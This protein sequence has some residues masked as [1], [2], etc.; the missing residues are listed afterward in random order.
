MTRSG[1]VFKEQAVSQKKN[2][3]WLN[4]PPIVPRKDRLD[5]LFGGDSMTP[6]VNTTM[7]SSCSK[8]KDLL[9]DVPTE[10]AL[11]LSPR[12]YAR[13]ERGKILIERRNKFKLLQKLIS[14][15]NASENIDQFNIMT[16]FFVHADFAEEQRQQDLYHKLPGLFIVENIIRDMQL[17]DSQ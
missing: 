1:I 17:A 4:Q 6:E 16:V 11:T 2:K 8:I 5:I 15:Y 9:R 13:W 10:K 7:T 12:D 14:I 3:G